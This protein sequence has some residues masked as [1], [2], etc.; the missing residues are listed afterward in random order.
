[1]KPLLLAS[2]LSTLTLAHCQEKP[3]AEARPEVTFEAPAELIIFQRTSKPLPNFDGSLALTIGDITAGQVETGISTAE[4]KVVLARRSL[5][6]GDSLIFERSGKKYQLQL[7][8]LRNVLIGDD[9]A[10][11]S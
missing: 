3:P 2:L 10:T 7:A 11:F 4:G 8:V 1:M 9:S 6:Q 5:R